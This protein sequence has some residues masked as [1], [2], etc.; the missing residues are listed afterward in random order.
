MGWS[1]AYLVV[2]ATHQ[3]TRVYRRAGQPDSQQHL[4][5]ETLTQAER[6]VGGT[7]SIS[8]D[9]D[10]LSKA[11]GLAFLRTEDCIP[12]TCGQEHPRRLASHCR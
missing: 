4:V 5:N 3:I 6:N 9:L 1:Y 11:A 12:H 8:R 7:K 10:R 2:A